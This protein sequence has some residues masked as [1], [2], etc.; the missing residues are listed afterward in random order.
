[1]IFLNFSFSSL[2]QFKRM[3]NKELSH[4]S[5]SK[6]GNQISEYI[7][8]TFLG[9]NTFKLYSIQKSSDVI[10]GQ[11]RNYELDGVRIVCGTGWINLVTFNETN[12]ANVDNGRLRDP[13]KTLNMARE[14]DYG[15]QLG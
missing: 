8:N 14:L 6:S 15:I 11:P 4:F 2:F 13:V 3:L 7:C 10:Y 9:K 5:E 12:L 1:M